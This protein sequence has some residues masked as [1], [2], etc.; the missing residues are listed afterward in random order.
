MSHQEEEGGSNRSRISWLS[1]GTQSF[2]FTFQCDDH[3]QD[4]VA[5]GQ[6]GP[7]QLCFVCTERVQLDLHAAQLPAVEQSFDRPIGTETEGGRGG[8][9]RSADDLNRSRDNQMITGLSVENV[10]CSGLN[11]TF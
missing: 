5:A 9:E 1:S 10:I 2:I 8:L 4:A 7:G 11:W 3:H 6:T